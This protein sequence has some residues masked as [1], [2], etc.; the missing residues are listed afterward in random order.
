MYCLTSTA[1][2]LPG[3]L[4]S[5]LVYRDRMFSIT[6]LLCG[7]DTLLNSCSP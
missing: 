7:M 6:D 1:S 2:S 4:Q 3:K 5:S